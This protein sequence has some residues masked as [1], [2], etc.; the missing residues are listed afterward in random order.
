M[1]TRIL[2][3]FQDTAVARGIEVFTGAKALLDA[4][5]N[6]AA[7]RAHTINH[8]GYLLLEAPTGSGKTLI[9]GNIV[10]RFSHVENAVWFWFAP[11]KGVV[12]Q[13][14]GFLRE[15]FA[16]LRL[17]EL[18]ED[19]AA[20]SSR[21]GDVF[22]TTWQTVATR[23]TDKRNARKDGELNPSIDAL[24]RGLRRQGFRIGVVVDEAHHGFHG[25]TL[26]AKFF[27]EVLDPEYTILITATPDDQDIKEFE[28]NLGIQELR[29]TTISRQAVVDAGLIKEGIRCVA[30]F[31]DADKRALVDF[32]AIALEDGLAFHRKIRQTLF[33]NG[34][35]LT[36]LM[37]VQADSSAGVKRIQKRLKTLGLTDR[38]IAVHTAE[39]PDPSLLALAN[40]EEREVLIFKMA[41]ALGF[42][43]PRAFTLVSMR[44]LKDPD[45]GVQ[46]V[47]RI[48]RVHRRLQGRRLPELLN[49]GYVFLSDPEAQTAIDVAGQRINQVRTEYAKTSPTTILVRVGERPE[50][51]VVNSAGQLEIFQRPPPSAPYAAIE[52]VNKAISEA[53][54]PQTMLN[55]VLD[56]LTA[57]SAMMLGGTRDR[58]AAA[59]A[60]PDGSFRFRYRRKEEAPSRFKSQVLPADF[61]ATEEECARQF[62]VSARELL[63]AVAGRVKV[64][65]RTLEVFRHQMTFE[66]LG[67]AMS[68]EQA[69]EEAE[70]VLTRSHAFHAKEL[71]EALMK[72]MREILD[73]N[74]LEG[75]EDPEKVE[76]FLDVLLASHPELLRKAQRAALIAHAQLVEAEEWPSEMVSREALPKS[77]LNGYGVIPAGMNSWE[78]GFVGI[79][80]R[81]SSGAILWWQRNPPH[82]PWSVR[83]LLNDG[84]GFFPDFILG[85]KARPKENAALLADTKF[86][87]ELGKEQAKILAEHQAYGRVL[88][89][90]Q[91]KEGQWAIVRFHPDDGRPVADTD[92]R[93]ADAAR[94]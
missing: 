64:Q 39:E 72:R 4:T 52:K 68:P 16:G 38:Q 80:D 14:L 1:S 48:L 85:V 87:F 37:L 92:F 40:D 45:F 34:F 27:H 53:N 73:C 55:L 70:R 62:M 21:R 11:F 65:K 66:D 7:S 76:G 15:E 36:P 89:L 9:A 18:D 74:S 29:R 56:S 32:E 91:I 10:A 20:D 71:R 24:V 50:V 2:K 35:K 84:R 46:I 81:D 5:P 54:R 61:K 47:G 67:V 83:V 23:V 6:D 57:P 28:A 93:I 3:D 49:Y 88:I 33:E 30:Y 19:R 13:T 75:A 63:T 31:T 82:K 17:R 51:R 44:A 59:V 43:A 77:R 94:Y 69:A 25:E 22:V 41:V 86:A 58:G 78:R 90:H 8:N 60:L 26:A 12:G 42:D 79:L